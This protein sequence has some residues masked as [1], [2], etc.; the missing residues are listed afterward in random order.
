MLLVLIIGWAVVYADRTCLYPLLSVIGGQLN[1]T[2]AQTGSLTSA[3]FLMYVL[4]QIPAGVMGDRWGL[5]RVLVVMFTIAAFGMLGLGLFGKTYGLLLLFAALHGFG[6]GGFYAPAYGT[7]L[8]TVKPE[9]MGFSSA[10]LGVGMAF[11]LMTGLIVSGPIYEAMGR[12]QPVFI[13]MAIPTFIAVILFMLK[14]PNIR[15]TAQPSLAQYRRM[16][17]DKDFWLLN[18][19][20]FTALYG[21]WVAVTWGPTYLLAEKGFSLLQ[22]GLY[23]G[24]VALTAVP[25]GIM[26]GRLSDKIGRKKIIQ[27]LLPTSAFCLFLLTRVVS[28]PTVIIVFLLY[29]ITANSAFC[30]VVVAW[31]GDLFKL[32]YPGYIGAVTGIHNCAIMSSAIVAPVV[33]GWLRDVTGS[34]VPALGFGVALMLLGSVVVRWIPENKP[35]SDTGAPVG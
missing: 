20:T 3:Y 4:M 11:G 25:A 5:R 28:P 12:Y 14:M 27:F 34:L 2:A 15:G 24:L 10:L 9:K 23:T 30:P 35:V 26:W 22:S 31:L 17:A 8:Q 21:F 1:L 32:R 33:S 6:A 16:L 29:G 7:L 19:V 13:I 18:F